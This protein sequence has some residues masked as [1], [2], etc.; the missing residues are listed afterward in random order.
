M[1]H[2]RFRSIAST[3]LLVVAL[4]AVTWLSRAPRIEAELPLCAHADELTGLRVLERLHTAGPDPGFFRYPTL[5]YYVVS[6]TVAV[7]DRDNDVL[8][9]GRVVTVCIS[10]CSVLL[11]F[12]F[13]RS[14]G[15]PPPAAFLAALLF[16]LSPAHML[17]AGY[18]NTDCLVT[19]AILA[20][21][22]AMR[23]FEKTGSLRAFLALSACTGIAIASKYSA[24]LLLPAFVLLDVWRASAARGDSPRPRSVRLLDSALP[25]QVLPALLLLAGAALLVFGLWPS[26]AVGEAAAAL[27]ATKQHTPRVAGVV[28]SL[29]SLGLIVGALL[30]PAAAVLSALARR[31]RVVIPYRSLAMPVIAVAVFLVLTPYALL[32]WRLFVYDVLYEASKNMYPPAASAWMKY[33]AWIVEF[34]FVPLL[35]LALPGAILAA[36]RKLPLA[37]PLLFSALSLFVIAVSQRAF[38]RYLLP[39][40]PLL[41]ILG[42]YAMREGLRFLSRR[43]RVAAVA[44]G[45]LLAALLV[46][47]GAPKVARWTAPAGRNAAYSEFL[48]AY[49]K[50]GLAPGRVIDPLHEL[51]L[52]VAGVPLARRRDLDDA[53]IRAAFLRGDA[54]LLIE[55]H[56]V[57]ANFA[58]DVRCD[59]LW[60]S[61]NER[62]LLLARR[63]EH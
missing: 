1:Y 53:G 32:S 2:A 9:V 12:A 58:A 14:I 4:A 46:W 3:C 42:V 43:N 37:F 47:D 38:L 62:L 40:L 21:F 33:P 8:L 29:Q 27:S 31:G 51:E 22:L 16:A 60:R 52:R 36:R 44:A 57:Y 55:T 10:L 6:A 49:P 11:L 7:L 45:L 25:A 63:M 54:D 50:L 59:T 39:V 24:A 34:E 61:S 35:L 48:A 26:A 15:L 18:I 56:G 20:A 28:A 23:S 30:P 5:E 41:S 17:A 19:A 13:A